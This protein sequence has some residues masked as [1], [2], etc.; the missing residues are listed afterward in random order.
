MVT[1]SLSPL[2]LRTTIWFLAKSILPTVEVFLEG[3][4]DMA[5]KKGLKEGASGLIR[6]VRLPL[7]A[8]IYHHSIPLSSTLLSR[9]GA[10]GAGGDPSCGCAYGSSGSPAWL[11]RESSVRSWGG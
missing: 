4:I 11:Q 7:I 1:R 3:L 9:A 6:S 5:S 10:V 8:A 2:P